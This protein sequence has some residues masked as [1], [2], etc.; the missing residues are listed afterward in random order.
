MLCLD[1]RWLIMLSSSL[2]RMLRS[3]GC[4]VGLTIGCI[5]ALGTSGL[6]EA[7]RLPHVAAAEVEGLHAC[8][9]AADVISARRCLRCSIQGWNQSECAPLEPGSTL[10]ACALISIPLQLH[11][12]HEQ[13]WTLL[14]AV[15][16][17]ASGR[18]GSSVGRMRALRIHGGHVLAYTP[19]EGAKQ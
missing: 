13:H 18:D 17:L 4:A 14:H 19:S 16:G 7:L 1:L 8:R 5:T 9:D 3:C 6:C 10:W 15:S 11:P 12:E 2:F